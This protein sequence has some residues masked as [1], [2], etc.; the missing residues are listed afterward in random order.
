MGRALAC[1]PRATPFQRPEWVLSWCRNFL[2]TRSGRPSYDARGGGRPRS[3]LHYRDGERRVIA[4]LAGGVSDYH[5]V[6]VVP[7][8][9]RAVIEQLFHCLLA[10]QD[11]WDECHFEE[12]APWSAL[13]DFAPPPPFEMSAIETAP[14]P[15]LQLPTPETDLAEAVP[16]GQLAR[17]RNI[18]AAP[19]G[20]GPC[21][22]ARA[23]MAK[24]STRCF[25]CTQRDGRARGRPACSPNPAFEPST[26][27]SCEGSV[28][29]SGADAREVSGVRIYSLEL[30]EVPIGAL[31]ALRARGVLYCYMQG[32]DPQFAELC[33]GLLLVGEVLERARQ[34]GAR[35][36]DFL[37]GDEPYKLMWGATGIANVGLRIELA[38]RD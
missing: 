13:R 32:I 16:A 8:L 11:T 21:G 23:K 9:S 33:P 10:A 20:R 30:G 28:R 17:F 37:R 29:S 22:F 4:F 38:R 24:S 1:C 14:C 15:T 19:S 5:D 25:V 36:V 31:Y 7:E 12:L 2:A 27:R 18:V 6:L 35:T 3:L 34:E 26:M